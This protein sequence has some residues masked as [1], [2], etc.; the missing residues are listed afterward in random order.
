MKLVQP[1]ADGHKAH[2][3]P[4]SRSTE[5]ERGGDETRTADGDALEQ[6]LPAPL[7]HEIENLIHIP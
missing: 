6:A 4:R 7:D 1:T 2:I 3:S 5:S